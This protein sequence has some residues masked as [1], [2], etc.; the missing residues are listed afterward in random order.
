MKNGIMEHWEFG[1]MEYWN[2]GTMK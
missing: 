1:M 2:D